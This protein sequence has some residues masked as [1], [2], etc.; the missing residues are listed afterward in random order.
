MTIIH[1]PHWLIHA[2][3]FNLHYLT[4]YIYI[5]TDMTDDFTLLSKIN[6]C[7]SHTKNTD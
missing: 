4:T 3:T 7:I 5:N 1:Y 6:L 2:S